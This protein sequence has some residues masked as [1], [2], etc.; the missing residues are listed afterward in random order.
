MRMQVTVIVESYSGHTFAERPIAFLWDEQRHVVENI[1]KRWRSPEG[2]GFRVVTADGKRFDLTYREDQDKWSL[3]SPPHT[4]KQAR[5]YTAGTDEAT[6]A[7]QANKLKQK[8]HEPH[9]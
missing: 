2:P 4:W 9:A 8:E 5:G 3:Q 6:R 7:S 1:I